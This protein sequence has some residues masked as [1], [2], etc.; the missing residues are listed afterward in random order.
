[1]QLPAHPASWRRGPRKLRIGRSTAWTALDPHPSTRRFPHNAQRI[2]R[3]CS[4]HQPAPT[5]PGSASCRRRWHGQ[6]P[7]RFNMAVHQLAQSQTVGQIIG[8]SALATR[9]WSSAIW[10]GRA[11]PVVA[12][13]GCSSFRAGF[14]C[15]KP[16]SPKP[17]ALSYPFTRAIGFV[18]LVQYHY[19]RQHLSFRWI[20]VYRPIV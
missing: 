2:G 10:I 8:S 11:A 15:Q 1:M 5:P 20:G 13:I 18:R 4:R 14:M 16:L 7:P 6:D 3:Q 12:S 17:G 19:G 9:R